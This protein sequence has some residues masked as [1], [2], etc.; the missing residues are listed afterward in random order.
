MRFLLA[1]CVDSRA[2]YLENVRSGFDEML[3]VSR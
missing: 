3:T 1:D 2:A